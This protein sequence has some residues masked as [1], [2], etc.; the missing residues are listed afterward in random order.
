MTEALYDEHTRFYLDFVD[1]G[2]ANGSGLLHVLLAT[3][4]DLVGDRA[5]GGVVLDLACGEGYVARHFASRA[6]RVT[7]VDISERLI[8]AARSRTDLPNV[9]FRVDDAQTL[10]SLDDSSCDVVVSQM[11]LM[12]IA[13]HAA[14]F[15]AVHRVLGARGV[16]VFSMLHPAHEGTPFHE[17]DEPKFIVD[18]NGARVAYRVS[19]YASEGFYMSGT[20]ERGGVRGRVGSY[21]RMISTYV[22]DL[23]RTGLVIEALREPVIEGAG[24]AAEIPQTMVVKVR[25]ETT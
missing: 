22:N 14:A 11:A 15:R 10:G 16:F 23:V 17:P 18:E 25:K 6:R 13:D 4:D 19:R 2:L 1:R 20:G 9:D 5:D 21:H 7:G 24:L 12:D 3:L 8:E